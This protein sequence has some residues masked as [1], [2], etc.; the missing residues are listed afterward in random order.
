MAEPIN[1]ATLPCRQAM[2][3]PG[4]GQIGHLATLAATVA[5]FRFVPDQSVL[6]FGRASPPHTN[7]RRVPTTQALSMHLVAGTCT[8]TC[9]GGLGRFS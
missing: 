8:S 5:L 7:G 9:H 1:E 3:L 2:H 6:A 4:A